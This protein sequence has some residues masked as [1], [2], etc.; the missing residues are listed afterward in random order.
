MINQEFYGSV[1]PIPRNN[2]KYIKKEKIEKYLRFFFLV[3][4]A[5]GWKL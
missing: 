4:P 5:A 1:K 3:P 2:N